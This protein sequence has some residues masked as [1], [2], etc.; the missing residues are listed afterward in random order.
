MN[1]VQT[2]KG[3][4][5]K[6]FE[7]Y[8][9]QIKVAETLISGKNVILSV[10][11]GAG[12]TWASVIPFLHARANPSISFPQKMIYSLPL[13][14]LTNSIYEDVKK[15]TDA[16]IQTGEYS[17]DKYFQNDI[18]FSTIDQTLSNFLCF[19]LALSP[20]QANINAGALVG[21]YLVFDEFHL[22]EPSLAMGTTLGMLKLLGNTCRWCIMTAT[23]SRSFMRSIPPELNYEIITLDN[24]PKDKTKIK[25]LLPT[26]NKKTIHIASSTINATNIIKYHADKTIVIC[27]RV[28]SAQAI[29]NELTLLQSDKPNVNKAK[30]ICLHSRYFDKDRKS[31]ENILKSYFGKN[32]TNSNVILIATQVIE[33]GMDISCSVMHTEIS[34]INSFLQRAGRCARFE[35]EIGQ[36]FVYDILDLDEHEKLKIELANEDDRAE[37]NKINN[38]YLPYQKVLTQSSL[39]ELSKHSTLDGDIP[40]ILVETVLGESEKMTVQ[41]LKDSNYN[42]PKIID[43]WRD[44]KK[45]NYRNTIR[46]IQSVEVVLIKES[47]KSEIAQYPFRYQSVG[48]FKWSLVGW[49]N[50]IS[51]GEG[52]KPYNIESNPLAWELSE[53]NFI[54]ETI[55]NDE[56]VKYTLNKIND[57]TQIP[58]QLYINAEYFGY[59]ESVGFNWNFE[60]TFGNVSPK[61]EFKE[62][63]KPFKALTKD[64]FYQH[65][66]GLINCFRQDFLPKI[67]FTSS[68]LGKMIGKPDWTKIEFEQLIILM[69]I[70]HDFGKLNNQWQKPMREYQSKKENIALNDFTDVLAHTDYDSNNPNDI[71]LEKECNLKS[72]GG[73]AGVGA[74]IAETV[75]QELFESA[76][77]TYATSMAIA[78]HHGP[79]LGNYLKFKIPDKYYLSMQELINKFEFQ[80]SISKSEKFEGNL[81]G[82]ETDEQRVLYLFLVRILRICDQNATENLSNY[83]K[84]NLN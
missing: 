75:I 28:E 3:I 10:T 20:R 6:D 44:C 37:I 23:M 69:I 64:T 18:I 8:K 21:S 24:Y 68:Q 60:N 81:N 82:L 22:L 36:I 53:N 67:N 70:L 83:F 34:P 2:Y 40:K 39:T 33:A 13:R 32:S 43:S 63:E 42:Y 59:S 66:M 52:I 56:D 12:K 50:K 61:R 15:V 26:T 78:R 80:I 16:S 57:F 9:Y 76:D 4:L 79:L 1:I 74:F 11:T 29:F 51:K 55:E 19:P 84:E 31:K 46:D 47:Q 65:N 35:N 62:I 45:N 30:I 17:E 49:L 14:T 25:S 48:M 54:G 38:K 77:I 72:R 58:P 71:A 27:N 5:G 7:P 73:H 41:Q